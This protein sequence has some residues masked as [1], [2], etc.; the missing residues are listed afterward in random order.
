MP[1][2]ATRPWNDGCERDPTSQPIYHRRVDR[3]LADQQ[4]HLPCSLSAP[5][6]SPV[7]NLFHA[8]NR[9]NNQLTGRTYGSF[10]L[11]AEDCTQ[12]TYCQSPKSKFINR[13]LFN[14]LRGFLNY[15]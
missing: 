2:I 7:R 8:R 14:D 9:E 15:W 3:V 6:P 11:L 4:L 1:G 13:L 12:L 10:E 5:P